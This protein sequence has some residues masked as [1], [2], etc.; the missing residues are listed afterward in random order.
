MR[1]PHN[2]KIFRGQFDAAPFA[3]VFFLL[4][5][6]LL[7]HSSMIFIPGVPIRLPETPPLPGVDRPTLVV[8]VDKDGQ[9][10][11][12]SQVCSEDLL[13]EKLQA[14]MADATAPLTLVV[15]ADKKVTYE[16]LVRLGLLARAVKIKEVLLATRPQVSPAATMPLTP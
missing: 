2:L 12:E 14:A 16:T 6:F 11:F 1:F 15:Q 7:L 5:I 10:Y 4:V 9:F 3:G 8:A 13:K